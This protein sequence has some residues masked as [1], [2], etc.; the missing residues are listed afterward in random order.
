[1]T[2]KL[3]V[4]RRTFLAGSAVAAGVGFGLPAMAA[5]QAAGATKAPAY[6]PLPGVAKLNANE[7]P[8]GPSPAA[9]KAMMEAI[10]K[11]AYYVN[12]S[13]ELLKAMIAERHGLSKDH[14]ILSS[15]SSGVLTSLAMV[16][17]NKG[18]ILG[19]DLF[20]DTTSKMG[21]RNSANGIKRIAKTIDLSID[22]EQMYNAIT[23]DVSLAQICNPNNPTGSIVSA[24][25]LKAF[26]L[27]A[28]KKT[29]VLVDE[30]Y[31]ELTDDPEANSMIPLVKDGHNVVVART[32][33]KIYGLAGMRVGY[34]IANPETIETVSRYGMGSYG[35]NQAGIAAAV[36]SYNDDK[37]LA[38]SKAKVL[39]AR[40][41]VASAVKSNGL[42][43]L[44]SQ[45][46]FMFVNLGDM[47]AEK[48]RAGMAKE[49]VL[50]RGVYQD[51]VHWSRVSMGKI[52]DVEKYVNAMPKVLAQIS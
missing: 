23:N 10:A 47:S 30:A 5:S 35:L 52:E 14:I 21:T 33:S 39:E 22:L 43:A 2:P 19:P 28:S 49:N 7:N 46:S 9:I 16:A 36:A 38:Y 15:G 50:I 26:C 17:A 29:M 8:Y 44:P 45:T 51:Y 25:S 48:F 42:T 1:M 13:A 31:N 12:D 18:D 41:M 6:G 27:K 20:W 32:F 40:E 3:N 24:Q 34:M 37:F 11:G 4:S